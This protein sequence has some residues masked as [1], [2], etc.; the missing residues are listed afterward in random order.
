MNN[1]WMNL[2]IEYY[3]FYELAKIMLPKCEYEVFKIKDEL[4]NAA[5]TM[6]K[7]FGNNQLLI[8]RFHYVTNAE[9]KDI[10]ADA[11]DENKQYEV[12]A[13]PYGFYFPDCP[14]YLMNRVIPG[15]FDKII[16]QKIEKYYYEDNCLIL[17]KRLLYQ[18]VFIILHEYGH[19]LSYKRFGG[20]KVAYAKHVY[21]TK[22]SFREYERILKDKIQ[23]ITDDENRERLLIYRNGAEE[24]FADDY[25]LEHLEEAVQLASSIMN[26]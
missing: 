4:V 6:P 18:A 13:M 23:I 16:E 1:I 3:S 8:P 20:D 10:L 17:N 15:G 9:E 14:L 12:E 26:N 25:A 2:E 7:Q 19:Y 21:E 24:K 22:R 5:I 11:W